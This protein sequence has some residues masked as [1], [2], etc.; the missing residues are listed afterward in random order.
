MLTISFSQLAL[1]VVV[2]VWIWNTTMAALDALHSRYELANGRV[3]RRWYAPGRNVTHPLHGPLV[4]RD[5]DTDP[6]LSHPWVYAESH[7]EGHPA[8]WVPTTELLPQRSAR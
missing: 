4:V 5:I 3:R 8:R 6:A 7:Y 1:I 2:G